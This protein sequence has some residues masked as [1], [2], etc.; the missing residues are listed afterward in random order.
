MTER[1]TPQQIRM[2]RLDGLVDTCGGQSVL[3]KLIGTSPGWVHQML[4]GRR[5][6]TEKTARKI[7][8]KLNLITGYLDQ[9]PDCTKEDQA[10][11]YT[12]TAEEIRSR[13]IAQL[14]ESIPPENRETFLTATEAMARG[15]AT[16]KD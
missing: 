10:P 9:Y 2:Y 8:T 3:A 12:V 1:K 13:Q 6:I 5:P 14:I 4:T 7:E 16:P 11:V 15:L